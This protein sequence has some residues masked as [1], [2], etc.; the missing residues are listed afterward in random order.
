MYLV[1]ETEQNSVV[2]PE[3][4]AKPELTEEELRRE[5]Q[6]LLDSQLDARPDDDDSDSRHLIKNRDQLE[7]H[8]ADCDAAEAEIATGRPTK[9]FSAIEVQA[10]M[11][12]Q[13][14]KQHQQQNYGRKSG[15]SSQS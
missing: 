11:N 1:N 6:A 15:S 3:Q 4:P 5:L 10:F 13:I 12:N 9:G 2:E 14:R 7:E 8:D